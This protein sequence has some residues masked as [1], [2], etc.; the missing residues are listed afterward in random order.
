MSMSAS[1]PE[2]PQRIALQ[3]GDVHPI[4]L[5]GRGTAGFVWDCS[6]EGA[7]GIVSITH[8]TVGD[9]PQAPLGGPPPRSYSLDDQ[10]LIKADSPGKVR[11]HF[12][13]HRP[14]ETETPPASELDVEVT[15]SKP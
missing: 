11:L 9:R 10:F 12:V 1:P 8:N 3:V 6:V 5:R 2:Q 15:V 4:R 14:W 13:Q 7:E